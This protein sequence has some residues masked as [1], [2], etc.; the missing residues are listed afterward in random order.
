MRFQY[1]TFAIDQYES[2]LSLKDEYRML[3]CEINKTSLFE[4]QPSDFILPWDSS[5]N[6]YR[7]LKSEV[8]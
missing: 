8:L 6:D 4:L 1:S 7:T 3:S 2:K 5:L